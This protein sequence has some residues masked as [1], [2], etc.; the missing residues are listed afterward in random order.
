MPEQISSSHSRRA[1]RSGDETNI[2]AQNS[3]AMT[4]K[5]TAMC[6]NPPTADVVSGWNIIAISSAMMAVIHPCARGRR[7]RLLYSMQPPAERGEADSECGDPNRKTKRLRSG[8][9]QQRWQ[10]GLADA[11]TARRIPRA[12][13]RAS[14]RPPAESPARRVPRSSRHRRQAG[15]RDRDPRTP[16]QTRRQSKVV[17]AA[18]RA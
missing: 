1:R 18:R 9:V 10:R 8:E 6:A 15:L 2:G 12:R 5:Y 4:A 17:I 16:G 14:S 13:T 7:T 3:G 11:R